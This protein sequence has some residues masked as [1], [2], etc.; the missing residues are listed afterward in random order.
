M[1][2]K[3]ADLSSLRIDRSSN[4]SNQN[5]KLFNLILILIITL[6]IIAGIYFLWEKLFNKGVSVN[7]TTATLVSQSQTS[8]ILTASGYVVAQR[9]AAI[10]SK[11]TGRLVYLGVVEGDPVVKGQIIGRLEDDDVK[12]QL[13]QAKATLKLYEADLISAEDNYKREK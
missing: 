9:K 12:S 8:A 11:A 2:T 6:L 13:D 4:N 3:N 10:A 5:K 7:L 1:E